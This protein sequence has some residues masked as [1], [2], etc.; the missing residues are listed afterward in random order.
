MSNSFLQAFLSERTRAAEKA[1]PTPVKS[2]ATVSATPDAFSK[3]KPQ[4]IREF[5]KSKPSGKDVEK[6]F[7]DKVAA[8]EAQSESD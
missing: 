8:L 4:S 2:I 6:W 7:R 3:A 1:L 5:A